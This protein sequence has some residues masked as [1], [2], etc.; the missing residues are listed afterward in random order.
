MIARPDNGKDEPRGKGQGRKPSMHDHGKSDGPVVP[1]KP[2]NNADSSVAEVVEERG[3]AKRVTAGKTGPRHSAGLNL[4]NALDRVR[5]AARKDKDAQFTALLHH[6][7]VDRLEV[8]YRAI[9]PKAAPGVDGVTWQTYGQQLEDNLCSLHA[10]LHRGAYRAKPTRR[11]YIPKTDGQLRPLGIAALEDKI[12]QRAVV[13]VLNAIYEEDFLGFSYGFRPKRSAHD[14]LDALAV[15]VRR[16]KVNWVLDA[17]IRGFF[18]AI[19]H[20]W[21]M[22]FIEHRIA[23]RRILRLIQK[24]LNAGVIE[25][26]IWSKSAEGTPQGASISTMLANVYLHYVFDLWAHQWR[27]RKACGEVVIV[28]YADDF[29]VGFTHQSDAQQFLSDLRRRLARFALELAEDKTRLIEFGRFAAQNRNRRGKGKPDT[30]DFLGFT[31]IC[32]KTRKG[33]FKLKRIS[34]KKKMKVKLREVKTELRQHRHLPVPEQGRWLASVVQ[35]HC[36]YYSVPDNSQAVKAFRLQAL[37]HW[38]RALRRRSQRDSLSWQR[39]GRL[40]ARWLPAVRILH[41]WPDDRFYRH[42]SRQEPSALNAHA[43]ICAGGC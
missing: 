32:A 34:S 30:F 25:D 6:V 15:A 7:T 28:R 11:A 35:G 36:A 38:W 9:R 18:D 24:W 14:A 4:S 21:L 39:M 31:H 37:R 10:R 22:K 29:V 19:D 13:E 2:P 5:K 17:D 27:D 12:V 8:A 1:A 26:G 20:E 40:E 16:K 3:P 42:H 33:R 41:P 43:G 23:D